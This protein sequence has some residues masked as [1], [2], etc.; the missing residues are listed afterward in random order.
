MKK[1]MLA[2]VLSGLMLTGT[3]V[4]CGGDKTPAAAAAL[5]QAVPRLRAAAMANMKSPPSAWRSTATT[6]TW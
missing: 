6:G 3:L 5:R 1:R 2:L 4:G